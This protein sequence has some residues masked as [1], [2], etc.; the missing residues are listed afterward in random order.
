VTEFHHFLWEHDKDKNTLVGIN[1]NEKTRRKRRQDLSTQY[2][3]AGSVYAMKT[4][5]FLKNKKRF[6]GKTSYYVSP[7]D[8]V[9]E[10]DVPIDLTISD[11]IASSLDNN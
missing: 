5:G 10:I 8:R 6:F 2:L 11:F 7:K 1:H 3:E 9:F 4:S